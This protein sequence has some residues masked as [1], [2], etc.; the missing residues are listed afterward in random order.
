MEKQNN[1]NLEDNTPYFK[2]QISLNE[3]ADSLKEFL[4]EVK[5][6]EIDR[7]KPIIFDSQKYEHNSSDQRILDYYQFDS[8][9]FIKTSN[10][11]GFLG[12]ENNSIFIGSRFGDAFL[13]Y[14]VSR[15]SGYLPLED[16][17]GYSSF[18]N[19][20]KMQVFMALYWKIR[21]TIASRLGFPKVYIKKT[22]RT[23]RLK[24]SLDVLDYSLNYPSPKYICHYKEHS[25]DN[26]AIYLFIKTY[27]TLKKN[28][29]AE[30]I[31]IPLKG[32]YSE[33]KIISEGKKKSIQEILKTPFFTNPYYRDYN[34][35]I[36]LSKKILLSE[37]SI[38]GS[39]NESFIFDISMLYEYFIKSLIEENILLSLK[40]K[41]E[42]KLKVSTGGDS[43][44]HHN[45]EPDFLW[46]NEKG[47]YCLFDAKYKRFV[48]SSGVKREDLFQLHT[49]L[50]TLSQ[51][52]E[53]Q[54]CG[55]I[56]PREKGLGPEK[57]RVDFI[58]NKE[59]KD[60]PFYIL[61]FDIPSQKKE[62][63]HF[64]NFQSEMAESIKSFK[65]IVQ[66]ITYKRVEEIQEKYKEY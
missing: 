48:S 11:V 20:E 21:L 23:S 33:M 60:I 15:S 37:S 8:H 36:T 42:L 38:T 29:K 46:E 27:E 10:L 45:L 32:I 4:K 58:E 31:L 25:Y 55:F 24:G 49:Y 64:K 28:P 44:T 59:G 61:F 7:E 63:I 56:Y 66:D 19:S 13:L 26:P 14:L 2:K 30:N 22:E 17:G 39:K 54:C 12:N 41:D 50:R 9:I 65:E 57:F 62:D 52:E 53:V 18:N 51:K 16:L 1:L 34:E 35:V 43:K 47:S 3:I 40:K 5:N 6:L